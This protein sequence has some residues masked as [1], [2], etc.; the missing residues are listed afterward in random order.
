[1][2]DRTHPIRCGLQ[3]SGH[4]EDCTNVGE[5]SVHICAVSGRYRSEEGMDR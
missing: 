2:G 3:V 4:G 5:C 1:M